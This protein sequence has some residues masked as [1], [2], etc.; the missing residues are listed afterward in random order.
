MPENPES[1]TDDQWLQSY[2]LLRAAVA[3][4]WV[5][6]AVTVGTS[7]PAIGAAL[8]LLYP[9][10]DA[11]ANVIDAQRH[12][13][14]T[15]NPTQALNVVVSVLTTGAVAIALAHSMN[16]VLGVFG[17]W[18]ALAGLFQLATGIRR[19]RGHGAQWAMI[20]SGAQSMLVGVL[21]VKQASAPAVPGIADIAPYAAFGAFY[22]LLSGVWLAVSAARRRSATAAPTSAHRAM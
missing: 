13:G 15:R 4:V 7:V 18:A 19:W 12:G 11:V 2:Y 14:A 8:L 16:A 21:F 9:A 6:A 3:G 22:F 10:W 5:A 20:L 17:A 1:T